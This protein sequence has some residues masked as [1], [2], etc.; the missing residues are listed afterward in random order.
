[1]KSLFIDALKGSNNHRPPVWLMRQAGRYLPQYQFY[2]KR[3]SLHDMFHLPELAAEVMSVTVETLGVD[4]AILFS[5]ILVI[6]EALGGSID[7]TKG[8]GPL[9]A[10]QIK[11]PEDITKLQKYPVEEK[12][13]Y[14]KKN[15]SLLKKSVSVPVIGFCGAPFT[16]AAYMLEERPSSSIAHLRTW[17]QKEPEALH[18]L[19]TIL[20]DVTIEY[21]E[22]QVKE[23]V[24]AIQV[25]ESWG[26][27]LSLEE[28]KQFAAPYLRKIFSRLNSLNIPCIVFCKNSMQLLSEL[29]SLGS[30]CISVDSSSSLLELRQKVPSS[31]S[32][33]GNLDPEFLKTA[34][35][36]DVRKSTLMMLEEMRGHK[37]YIANLGHG[38]LPETP[39]ENVMTF[40]ETV[41]S[42]TT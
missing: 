34:T 29:T 12:L 31:L 28:F 21:L 10:P 18:K 36:E 13:G 22:M 3:Y 24:E 4:A 38:I 16:I 30:S 8:G 9:V 33:Q 1:M 20:T 41:K 42:F 5:D 27:S 37:G 15:I 2:R 39:V 7:F 35:S 6:V 32:I 14:V 19:L 25:F 40:I 26:H 23:G 17:I 11:S